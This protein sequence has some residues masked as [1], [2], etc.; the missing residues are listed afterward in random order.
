MEVVVRV[1][2]SVVLQLFWEP[3]SSNLL[4]STSGSSA[5]HFHP[6]RKVQIDRLVTSYIS[7]QVHANAES[8]RDEPGVWS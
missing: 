8:V 7:M 4:V 5:M 2:T 3:H 6:L 1:D